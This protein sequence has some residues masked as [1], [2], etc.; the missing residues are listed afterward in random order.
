MLKKSF[1]A[2]GTFDT[3]VLT[4][5]LVNFFP[6][7]V[8]SDQGFSPVVLVGPPG[9]TKSVG[10]DYASLASVLMSPKLDGVGRSVLELRKLRIE[11]IRYVLQASRLWEENR[12]AKGALTDSVADIL[13]TAKPLGKNGLSRFRDVLGKGEKDDD[14]L[15]HRKNSL[16]SDSNLFSKST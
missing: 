8:G 7:P 4:K 15:F 14:V 10:R 9:S 2:R 1:P 11:I 5:L 12:K 6:L 16:D 13:D 3:T